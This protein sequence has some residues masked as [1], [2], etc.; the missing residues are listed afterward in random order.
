MMI[1]LIDKYCNAAVVHYTTWKSRRVVQSI[2]AAEVYAL[3]ACNDYCQMIRHDLQLITGKRFPLTILIDS[4]S[5]F[6]TITKLSSLSEKRL[7]IDT[8]ALRQS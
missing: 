1:V 8:A 6:D 3:A 2:L 4:K 7:L 5:I